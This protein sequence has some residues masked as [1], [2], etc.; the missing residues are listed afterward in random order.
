MMLPFYILIQL[1]ES[2]IVELEIE[3][4]NI[5]SILDFHF[6]VDIAV[7][8]REFNFKCKSYLITIASRWL[9]LA[10]ASAES[11]WKKLVV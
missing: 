10:L 1:C 2:H 11:L 6:C 5:D 8:S 7:E 3:L 4:S 9:S